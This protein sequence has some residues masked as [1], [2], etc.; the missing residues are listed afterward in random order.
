MG[1]YA[2][3]SVFKYDVK[4]SFV[5]MREFGAFLKFGT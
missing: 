1:F 5:L 3:L 4:V 2:L